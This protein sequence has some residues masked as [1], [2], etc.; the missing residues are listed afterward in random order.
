MDPYC[1][2]TFKNN[3]YKTKV[4][5]KAGKK[6]KWTDEFTLEV[7]SPTDEMTLRCW[8]QDLTTSDAIGFTKIKMSSLM[9]NCGIEDWFT[10]MFDNKPA[11]EIFI[12]TTFTPKGGNE[13]EN[14]KKRHDEEVER[15]RQEAEAAKA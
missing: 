4:C 3:K 12:S 7:E 11:G 2:I 10:I 15:L 14:M 6:P 13:Y 9:I 5:D 8:D 1:T